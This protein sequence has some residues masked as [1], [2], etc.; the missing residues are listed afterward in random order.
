MIGLLFIVYLS[1]GQHIIGVNSSSQQSALNLGWERIVNGTMDTDTDWIYDGTISGGEMHLTN[2]ARQD[3]DT[4][5]VENNT[6]W[7]SFDVT[8]NNATEFQIGYYTGTYTW[9]KNVTETGTYTGTVTVIGTTNGKFYMDVNGG[10]PDVDV[11]NV[12]VKEVL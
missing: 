5:F 2:F 10:G 8:F 4:I 11:D 6:Y 3:Y 12:S 7:Y 9:F 1:Y